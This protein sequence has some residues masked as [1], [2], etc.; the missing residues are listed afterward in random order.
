[1]DAIWFMKAV[2]ISTLPE[3]V[4]EE[5]DLQGEIDRLTS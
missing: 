2:L 4:I 3:S 1:M 5:F